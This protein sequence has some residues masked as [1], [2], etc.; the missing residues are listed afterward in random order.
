M[1]ILSFIEDE[2]V[3]AVKNPDA[4]IFLFQNKEGE[5]F[6]IFYGPEKELKNLLIE[7]SVSWPMFIPFE[8]ETQDIIRLVLK[9]QSANSQHKKESDGF[10]AA[11]DERGTLTIGG[12]DYTFV[13]DDIPGYKLPLCVKDINTFLIFVSHDGENLIKQGGFGSQKHLM[14]F[15]ALEEFFGLETRKS[16][17]DVVLGF[18]KDLR[19]EFTSAIQRGPYRE[20]G[21]FYTYY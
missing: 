16:V 6:H 7:G 19:Y 15:Y 18:V 12:G 9:K 11:I 10:V 8:K 5:I 17:E 14:I 2:Y 1:K 4:F 3:E 20:S 21:G 13:L